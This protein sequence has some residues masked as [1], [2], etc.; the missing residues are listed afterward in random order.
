[1]FTVDETVICKRKPFEFNFF[2]SLFDD[3]R[4][5]CNLLDEVKNLAYFR[6]ESDLY[7]FEQSMDFHEIDSHPYVKVF[8]EV[9]YG[10]LKPLVESMYGFT[11]NH[12]SITASRYKKE[13]IP[14]TYN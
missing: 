14:F 13:G 7:S 8:T 1:M 12:I 9:M 2:L 6:K 5:V 10:K 3:Q 4:Y 11:C